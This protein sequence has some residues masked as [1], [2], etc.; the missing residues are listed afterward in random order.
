MYWRRVLMRTAVI[1]NGGICPL[2]VERDAVETGHC[3]SRRGET[4]FARRAQKRTGA[5][6]REEGEDS[7]KVLDLLKTKFVCLQLV[8][9]VN[10]PTGWP[11]QKV[12]ESSWWCEKWSKA[13][14]KGQISKFYRKQLRHNVTNCLFITSLYMYCIYIYIYICP[15]QFFNYRYFC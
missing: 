12:N 5:H 14:K 13:A 1:T 2:F 6:L 10:I 7:G 15:L 4:S 11:E 8:M 9:H 3:L